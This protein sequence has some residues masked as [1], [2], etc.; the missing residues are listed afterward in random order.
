[1][2]DE[3]MIRMSAQCGRVFTPSQPIN[4]RALF[5]GRIDEIQRLVD[6]I[7]SPGRH[8][9]I[10]GDRGVGKTSLASI[11][12][13]LFQGVVDLKVGKINCEPN[14]TFASVWDKALAEIPTP[15]ERGDGNDQ[16]TLN[17]WLVLYRICWTGDR[18]VRFCRRRE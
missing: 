7:N 17:Q 18:S 15:A 2:T 6:S 12:T 13:E 11:I 3:Q 1:M 10:Y 14:D 8:P 16:Y 9:I 4:K 5:A